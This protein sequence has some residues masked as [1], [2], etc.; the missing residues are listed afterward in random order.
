MNEAVKRFVDN[1]IASTNP[2]SLRHNFVWTWIGNGVYFATQWGLL[3]VLAK[4]GNINLVG[5]YSLASAIVAPIMIFSQ[6]QLR[7]VVVTDARNEYQYSDYY[8][9]RVICTLFALITTSIIILILGYSWDMSLIML[10]LTF[11]KCFESMSDIIYGKLQKFNRMDYI[12][13]SMMIK[14]VLTLVLFCIILWIMQNLIWALLGTVL[15]WAS[16]YFFFDV[17]LAN[18]FPKDG[19]FDIRRILAAF[20]Q[21]FWLSLPLS[22]NS[23]LVSLSGYMPRYFLEY[24]YGKDAVGLFSIASAPLMFIVLFHNS[25]GQAIMAP[26]AVY[27]QNRELH[28]FKMLTFKITAIFLFIGI[29]FTATFAIF[30]EKLMSIIFSPQYISTVPVLII[31]SLGVTLNGFSVFGFMVIVAGRMFK[32]Q[33]INI[34]VTVAVQIPLCYFLIK[35]F[36]LMGAGWADF[37]KTMVSMSFLIIAGFVAYKS[38]QKEN[39]KCKMVQA[40][41]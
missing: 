34:I 40:S 36:G 24:N 11:A 13:I 21:I 14:G 17:K 41:N 8:W 37:S 39:G 7:Q 1:S 16:I 38:M 19:M 28:K 10:L 5:Q 32:L 20:K 18:K 3:V 33:L 15:V 26:A 35:K 22:F 25:I 9:C 27:F 23:A 31:M 30:G 4:F 12:A 2:L 6:M 29:L